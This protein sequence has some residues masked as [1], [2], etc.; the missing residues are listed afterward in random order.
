[1][2]SFQG[3]A[4]PNLKIEEIK[5][6]KGEE[7]CYKTRKIQLKF[8][9][10][11]D[12]GLLNYLVKERE[13]YIKVKINGKNVVQTYQKVDNFEYDTSK[14][15]G[16]YAVGKYEIY[17]PTVEAIKTIEIWG[18]FDSSGKDEFKKYYDFKN[19]Y[20]M[21]YNI[22]IND[23]GVGYYVNTYGILISE[24]TYSKEITNKSPIGFT[25]QGCS[26]D[27]E[28]SISP[29][30]HC[31]YIKVT[32]PTLYFLDEPFLDFDEVE[33]EEQSEQPPLKLGA[34]ILACK[35][36]SI[37]I[38]LEDN[39]KVKDLNEPYFIFRNTTYNIE[40]SNL[41][42]NRLLSLFNFQP[43][44]NLKVKAYQTKLNLNE[45]KIEQYSYI[46][47]IINLASPSLFIQDQ[48]NE[49]GD[50]Q[51][52][53]NV[54]IS[55]DGDS[56]SKKVIENFHQGSKSLYFEQTPCSEEYEFNYEDKK[57][58]KKE[59][60]NT[61]EVEEPIFLSNKEN[62]TINFNAKT[63]LSS[64]DVS[65]KYSL[66]GTE[67]DCSSEPL[68]LDEGANIFKI[69]VSNSK[70]KKSLSDLN[71]ILDPNEDLNIEI[72]PDKIYIPE[73]KA[74]VSSEK[75]KLD[76]YLLIQQDQSFKDPKK[77]IHK[78]TLSILLW[79]EIKEY[80]SREC[81]FTE[82]LIL[83]IGYT[84]QVNN[85]DNTNIDINNLTF[86]PYSLTFRV[87]RTKPITI[88]KCFISGNTLTYQ[89]SDWG[90]DKTTNTDGN[91]FSP[92]KSS[93]YRTGQE[94]LTLKF[95][96]YD[97]K[98]KTKTLK[99]T[100]TIGITNK[101]YFLENVEHSVDLNN[102]LKDQNINISE[103][104]MVSGT[105]NYSFDGNNDNQT[106]NLQDTS[107][108]IDIEI[109]NNS[110]NPTLSI[111]ENG[112]IVNGKP[113]QELTEV[114]DDNNNPIGKYYI[115]I[116]ALNNN[117]RFILKY[118]NGDCQFEIFNNKG[119]YISTTNKGKTTSASLEDILTIAN[120]FKT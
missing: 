109:I 63:F 5:N 94:K 22:G 70:N 15:Y 51:T 61:V 4:I 112:L 111:R 31:E 64:G 105:Y 49:Q 54:I 90:G 71:N 42:F 55:K 38:E 107:G 115:E 82:N 116:N 100:I 53:S 69:N 19:N 110:N 43:Q 101:N 118:P 25:V 76:I 39:G 18:A 72:V 84:T 57:W 114:L 80:L 73:L 40:Y 81:N 59:G 46:T 24:I 96:N 79:N 117:D 87:G 62:Y 78:E 1:M 37:I 67:V 9:V 35:R 29:Y 92:F 34:K 2:A 74:L 32:S 44:G 75:A 89:L 66:E 12:V 8:G 27:G 23:D 3:L 99:G 14:N 60:N 58:R 28:T 102:L 10:V 30:Y 13:L 86:F 26:K 56:Q 113:E 33:I 91:S 104:N 88:S 52:F 103:I 20:L 119:I 21:A 36:D 45:K 97:N 50:Y 120:T 17:L 48:F 16:R 85:D 6:T 68:F 65:L 108:K 7:L 93:F 95:F 98:T 83:K 106:V 47:G 77:N 41:A 11:R